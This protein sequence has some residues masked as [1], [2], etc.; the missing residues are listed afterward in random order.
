[1]NI[2]KAIGIS[3]I[4]TN[5]YSWKSLKSS[6]GAQIN[7]VIDRSDDVITL[8]EMKYSTEEYEITVEYEREIN[9]KIDVFKNETATKKAIHIMLVTPYGL[10]KN[11]HSDSVL[12]NI[13]TD[14]LFE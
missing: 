9:N 4:E 12:R 7:L 2:K 13:T 11:I 5:V 14:C 10:K 8:C 6:P 3:G 1:M